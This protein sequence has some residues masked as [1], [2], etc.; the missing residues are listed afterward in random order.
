MGHSRCPETRLKSPPFPSTSLKNNRC[1][2]SV[3]SPTSCTRLTMVIQGSGWS[4]IKNDGVNRTI[5]KTYFYL[6]S[7]ILVN[8]V[9]LCIDWCVPWLYFRQRRP[10]PTD[11]VPIGPT[12]RCP[13]FCK[14]ILLIL[15]SVLSSVEITHIRYNKLRVM[16]RIPRGVKCLLLCHQV[17]ERV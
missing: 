10:Y 1:Y 13:S 9:L 17:V 3:E 2:E 6:H 11:Y 7:C 16:S 4:P 5:P 15:S 12:P 8:T 14:T